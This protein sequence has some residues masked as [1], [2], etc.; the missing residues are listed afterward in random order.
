MTRSIRLALVALISFA[1]AT[2]IADTAPA[3]AASFKQQIVGTW[4]YV[5]VDIAKSDGSRIQPFGAKPNGIAIFDRNGHFAFVLTRPDVPK[6][7]SNNRLTGTADENRAAVRGV[8]AQ[9]GTYTVNQADHSLTLHIAG[10]SYPNIVGVDRKFII[11]AVTKTELKWTV[12][13][14][15][16]GGTASTVL[17]RAP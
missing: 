13:A 15:T 17:K 10:S 16:S 4:S 14:A 11:T 8:L 2:G 5:S 7:A 6:Y 12:P 3:R 1:L 9:F